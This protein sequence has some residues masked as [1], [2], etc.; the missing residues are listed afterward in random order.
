VR[1]KLSII[2]PCYNDEAALTSLLSSL[3]EVSSC[4]DTEII[5]VDGAKSDVCKKIVENIDG[6]YLR[7]EASRGKQIIRGV[8]RAT[9]QL[10]WFL[11]AD[12]IVS[13]ISL[14]VVMDACL[15]GASAGYFRFAFAGPS[16]RL[17]RFLAYWINM[18]SKLGGIAYGDQGLFIEAN[19]YQEL[20][21]HRPHALFEEVALMRQLKRHNQ[22]TVLDADIQVD[23]RRWQRDGFWKRTIINRVCATAYI[24]GMSAD[25]IAEWYRA[26]M[27]SQNSDLRE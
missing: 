5:V 13:P 7:E 9:G 8:E 24:F 27:T 6:H 1:L 25:K 12:A 15:S 10:Y 19:L 21:G 14:R 26:S 17:T 22:I 3:V 16:T 18:R 20:G 11:H 4:Y 23:P 2:I